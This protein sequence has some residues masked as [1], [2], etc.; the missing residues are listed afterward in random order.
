MQRCSRV[1]GNYIGC[2]EFLNEFC[3]ICPVLTSNPFLQYS[4]N[5]KRIKKGPVF[6]Q[7]SLSIK[8]LRVKIKENDVVCP[9]ILLYLFPFYGVSVLDAQGVYKASFMDEHRTAAHLLLY[10]S[11]W[12]AV[13]L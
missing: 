9:W 12:A 6:C 2:S 1:Q 11:K 7:F 5:K 10:D 4:S 13:K 3:R 8:H